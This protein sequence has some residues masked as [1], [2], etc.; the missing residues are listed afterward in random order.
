MSTIN[1]SIFDENG[2]T[3][4]NIDFEK[5]EIELTVFRKTK[6]NLN[7]CKQEIE[8]ILRKNFKIAEDYKSVKIDNSDYPIPEFMNKDM[9]KAH[10]EKTWQIVFYGIFNKEI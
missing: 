9:L 6:K 7:T 10:D 1:D 4:I 2:N 8:K 5:G 3:R